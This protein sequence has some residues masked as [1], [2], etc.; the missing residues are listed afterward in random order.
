MF[1][2][3]S[4]ALTAEFKPLDEDFCSDDEPVAEESEPGEL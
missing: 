4:P 3:R 1:G 2:S